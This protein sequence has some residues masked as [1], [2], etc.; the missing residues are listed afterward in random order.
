[1]ENNGLK[2][3][4]LL[5]DIRKRMQTGALSYEAARQEAEPIIKA[6]NTRAEQIAKENGMRFKKFTFSYL[7]R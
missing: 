1:M 7:M 4:E 6:M 3:R 2:N 5:Q